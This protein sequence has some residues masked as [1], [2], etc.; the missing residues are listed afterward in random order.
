[1][2]LMSL[3]QVGASVE[4][5][6]LFADASFGL[7][8]ED[9]V[10]VVGPNGVGKTTLLRIITGDREPDAGSLVP[11]SGLRVGWLAQ[12][13]DLPDATAAEVVATGDPLARDDEVA[14]L[15]D[16]LG[17]DGDLP[18]L[19]GSGGQRRRV[20]LART[21]LAPSDL[22]V[23][24]EPT[25]HLDV[26]TVDWLEEELGRR[27]SGLVLVTHDR[28]VLER[29]VNRMLDLQPPA[30]DEPAEVYWHEGAYSSLLEARAERQALRQRTTAR[31]R[32]LYSKEVAWLRRSPKART[33]KPRFR[34]EQAERLRQAAV[35]DEES[36]PLE[37][38]TGATR[39][40]DEVFHL[41]QVSITR[42]D[43]L[44]L[45]RVDLTIGPGERVGIVGPNGAGKTTLLHV[46]AGQLTPDSGEVTVGRTVQ[47]GVFEQLASVPPGQI[48]ALDT[49]LDI[50]PHVPLKNGERLPA[51][52]LA[53]RFGFDG[54]TQ[55]TP[56]ALLS[57][58]ERRRLALLHLLVAAPN[59]LLLDEPTND[60]DLDTLAVLEDHLDGFEGTLIVASH[61]RFLLDR[62]TDRIIGVED[63]RLSEHLDWSGYREQQLAARESAAARRA[64][65]VR[66]PS[67]TAADNARRQQERKELRRLEQRLEK[68]QSHR[69]QLFSQMVTAAAEPE[70]L[71]ALQQ[72]LVEADAELASVE[73]RW[74][75]LSLE[76]G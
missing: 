66:A 55:R 52:R 60:L 61:D 37:L 17:V 21:L 72:Q 64:R 27:R 65:Q 47:H 20:A 29:V 23:L 1:M 12:D 33:S 31:A 62:V 51:H 70:Q 48:T 2:H 6:T 49:V 67:D 69:E 4:G 24:D 15:L 34:V 53:E 35:G 39:L 59:V 50:A 32:N 68:L 43:H 18:V 74:L 19:R 38:G 58:G 57:G 13:V 63:G 3:E 26:D 76:Q 36:R 56:V 28:Y 75:E 40:G 7:S 54:R 11:R 14:A 42:G 44:V 25:N 5:R 41:E 8:S 9:R 10:G 71:M 30:P 16:H 46:L 73:D 45:D 22:L